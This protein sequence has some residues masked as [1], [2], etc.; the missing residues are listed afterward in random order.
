MGHAA[1]MF[2][3][4]R[5]TI[6]VGIVSYC[7]IQSSLNPADFLRKNWIH[8]N[9]WCMLEPLILWKGNTV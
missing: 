5:E 6:V 8:D 4:F 9:V 2:H 1:L 3:R 7:F